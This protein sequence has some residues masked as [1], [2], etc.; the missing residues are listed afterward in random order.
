MNTTKNLT[1]SL[2]VVVL[3][4]FC[5]SVA[6]QDF[7]WAKRIGGGNYD[8]GISIESDAFGNVYTT[9]TFE[10]TVDFDPGNGIYNLTSVGGTDIFVCKLDPSGNFGWVK[11]IAGVES[12]FSQDITI[13]A[14]GNV[15]TT[16]YFMGSTDFDPGAGNYTLISLGNDY[17]SFVS[18]LD[19]AGNFVW[20]VQMG[21]ANGHNV[22][23]S[24]ALDN[25]G[26]VYTTGYF[27]GTSDFNPGPGSFNLTSKGDYDIF[28]CK[29]D[30]LGNF[31]WAW[32]LGGPLCNISQ[33]IAIDASGNVYTTGYFEGNVDFDPSTGNYVLT[34]KGG[35]DAYISK[36]NSSGNFVWAK[37]IGG[38]LF[39]VGNSIDIDNLGNVYTIGHFEGTADFD[40]GA[41]N[42][43]LTAIG[44]PDIYLSKLNASGNFVWAKQIGGTQYDAG[45]SIDLD[46][47]GGIY[48]TGYFSDTVDFDPGVGTCELIS[49]GD[50]DIFISKLDASGNFE[51]VKQMGGPYYEICWAID[52]NA[53][54]YIYTT[55]VFRG[56]GDYDPGAGLYNLTSAGHEDIF[57]HKLCAPLAPA[58][59]TPNGNLFICADNSTTLNASGIGVLGWYSAETGGVYLGGGSSYLTPVLT[60]TTTYYVQDSTCMA[61]P[62][63]AVQ[64][65]VNPN[66]PVMVS[67]T[68][69][70]DTV[71]EGSPVIY[72]ATTVNG[73][74]SP[75]YL[76]LVNGISV[77]TNS[78]TYTYTP[79]NT[80][81]VCVILT[82]NEL[83]TSGNP[84]TSN[85]IV[86]T[87]NPVL[88]VSVS[89][90]ASA[91]NFC[92]GSVVI[93]SATPTHGGKTPSYQWN[94]NNTTAG[95]NS[96]TY[97]F[98]PLNN[99]TVKVIMTS[100]EGCTSINPA[101]S[102]SITM[103]I[104]PFPAKPF[105]TVSNN[106]LT[107]NSTYGNQWYLGNNPISGAINQ[108]FVATENGYY[109]V[110]VTLNGCSSEMSDS[111]YMIITSVQS[112]DSYENIT[113]FPNPTTGEIYVN[114]PA[115]KAGEFTM[116]VFN[117]AGAKLFSSEYIYSS[118]EQKFPLDLSNL[119]NGIYTLLIQQ[120]ETT[121]IRKM[122]LKK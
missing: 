76:W 32:Q 44:G 92:E 3:M 61:S 26:Y 49:K 38:P 82:S 25:S 105:I 87:V 63:I 120:R 85:T 15:Y 20:A 12:D 37:Q 97:T 66:W 100:S 106:T 2:L 29:L 101:I 116:Q 117:D 64:V 96:S 86:M 9:G 79:S 91:N 73:G 41:N 84:A 28:I 99:D 114:I 23:N 47:S 35:Y 31:V 107:S 40:P 5:Y 6:A 56:T 122:I 55:G 52:F 90:A 80:D 118:F 36:L 69:S 13:D 33:S 98:E 59:T 62:R 39:D 48:S 88:E 4:I 53:Y 34:A 94:V 21:G 24:I 68:A 77:S 30:T 51:W 81:S 65:V 16:G 113:V 72:T 104:F 43:N 78:G 110:M 71:C 1:A 54:G 18:K 27:W 95:I 57:I 115:L 10:G 46:A 50:Y 111:T 74:T 60:Y 102:N 42:Y 58:N 103:V 109:S 108:H 7:E 8:K 89:I 19:S 11:Q 67:I 22:G 119:P 14:S 112:S 45:L 83:C 75:Y 121:I 70:M 93:M 17:D